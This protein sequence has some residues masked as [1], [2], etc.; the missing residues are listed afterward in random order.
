MQK[1]VSSPALLESTSLVLAYGQDLF[2][3]RVS[4]SGTFD[5]LSK[6]FNKFQLVLIILGLSV[7][8]V[9]VRPIVKNRQLRQQWYS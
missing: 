2:F 8:I 3:T 7:A 5:L 6:S 9:F 1:I 4:P